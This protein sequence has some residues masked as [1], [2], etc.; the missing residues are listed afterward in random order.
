[1]KSLKENTTTQLI[2]ELSV[3]QA[4]HITN[5]KVYIDPALSMPAP[6]FRLDS[7]LN[8]AARWYGSYSWW[9]KLLIGAAFVGVFTGIGVLGHIIIAM[10][11][12]SV[13]VY[14]I[15][16]ALLHNHYT[17]ST[18]KELVVQRHIDD[19]QQMMQDSLRHLSAL[20]HK[21]NQVLSSLEFLDQLK[22][23]QIDGLDLHIQRFAAQCASLSAADLLLGEQLQYLKTMFQ[24]ISDPLNVVLFPVRNQVE[25][26]TI[27][28][29]LHSL[30]IERQEKSVLVADACARLESYLGK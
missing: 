28:Q 3:V 14:C 25:P 29:S 7:Y 2:S 24:E 20:E 21:L 8:Q 27:Q 9:M 12:V 4:Q 1:M 22:G 23:Q 15:I 6:L 5:K 13:V 11:I 30:M 10:S 26:H 17:H 16:A 19:W 18:S